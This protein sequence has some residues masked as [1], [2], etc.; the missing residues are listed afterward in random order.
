MFFPTVLKMG[1]N[2]IKDINNSVTESIYQ[3]L[4]R[5]ISVH[6]IVLICSLDTAL[7][8]LNYVCN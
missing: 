2:A 8:K 7:Y 6:A 4:P 1:I 5:D 3:E